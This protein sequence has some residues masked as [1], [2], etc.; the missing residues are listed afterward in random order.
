MNL[1]TV[2]LADM[3]RALDDAAGTIDAHMADLSRHDGR[4]HEDACRIHA[5]LVDWRNRLHRHCIKAVERM[6]KREGGPR[7]RLTLP[8][9]PAAK[10][11]SDRPVAACR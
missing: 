6:A 9:T 3:V 2:R 4:M 1:D 7:R 11:E 8:E 5:D 10:R